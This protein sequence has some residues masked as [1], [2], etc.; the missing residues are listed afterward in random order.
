MRNLSSPLPPPFLHWLFLPDRAQS[1]SQSNATVFSSLL[2]G[3]VSAFM[4]TSTPRLVTSTP[5]VFSSFTCPQTV[6]GTGV[7]HFILPLSPF[8]GNMSWAYGARLNFDMWCPSFNGESRPGEGLVLLHSTQGLTLSWNSP[9]P[10]PQSDDWTRYAC[11][12]SDEG[13]EL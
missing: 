4:P 1:I 9:L 12:L 8:S 10:P 7:W 3:G 13:G 2:T 5:T 11:P 6:F